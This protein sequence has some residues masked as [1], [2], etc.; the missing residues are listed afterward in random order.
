[1]DNIIIIG[2]DKRQTE[3]R[4]LLSAQGYRCRHISSCD[5][6]KSVCKIQKGDIIV[7]PVPVSKGNEDIYFS[8]SSFTVKLNDVLNQADDTNLI[9][10]GGFSKAVKSYLDDKK[11]SC[12][13]YLDCEEFVLYNAYLTGLGV[14]RLLLANS[15]EDIRDKKVLITG[16]GRVARFTA[17]A[18]KQAGCDVYVSARN[19]LQL[20]EAQC[21]GYKLIDFK[22]M[23]S[24]VYLFDFIFN[25]VPENI[26][27]YEDINHLKGK[28]FELASSPFGVRREYFNGRDNDYIDGSSLPGRYLYRSA[29]EILAVI[30][31]KHI[32]SRNGGD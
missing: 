3:L 12:F 17:Q 7:L 15:S 10:G 13:D 8:D 2:G 20:T 27:S 9:F 28:Y 26:F 19:K 30:T 1:M 21:V 24:F 22:K 31:L 23:S 29:A 32:N 6:T 25:T 16:F 4:N 14:V 5:K 11:I 18:L